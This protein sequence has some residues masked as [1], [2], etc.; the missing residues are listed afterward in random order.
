MIDSSRSPFGYHMS[1]QSPLRE[2]VVMSVNIIPSTSHGTGVANRVAQIKAP[3]ATAS[4]S[5]AAAIANAVNS[6]GHSDE[7]I[8]NAFAATKTAD[9][10]AKQAASMGLNE[11]QIQSAMQL[12]GYGGSDPS[13]TKLNIEA[14]VGNRDNGYGWDANGVLTALPS[15]SGGARS[16][17]QQDAEGMT[18][19]GK[20]YSTQ[21]IKDLY[22]GGKSLNR[23]LQQQGVTD[24]VQ[25]HSLNAQAEQIAGNYLTGEAALQNYFKEYQQYNPNG[26][27]AND[28]AGWKAD[29]D[30]VRLTSMMA[31]GF[32]GAVTA[33]QD[34]EPGGI[35]G[36]GSSYY[37]IAGYGSGLG[38]RGMGNLGGGWDSIGA[39]RGII[40]AT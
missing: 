23:I 1:N 7:Q 36:P 9:A 30:P 28:Y 22:A 27:H 19:A 40:T 25:I 35:Y 4:K 8:K 2:G 11:L 33:C 5:F 14:W 3:S 38:P 39:A 24:Q 13:T 32:T 34:W 18:M 26:A 16:S 21:Q 37:G 15:S 17:P 20:F 12:C 31:G 29:Q 6:G 10:F